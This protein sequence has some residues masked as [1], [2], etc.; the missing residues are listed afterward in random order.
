M[1]GDV[2]GDNIVDFADILRILGVWGP[3]S[4]NGA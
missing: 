4:Q 2:N 1:G 3:C